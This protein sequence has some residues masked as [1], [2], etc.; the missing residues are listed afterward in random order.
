[1]NKIYVYNS[2]VFLVALSL[3]GLGKAVFSAKSL[4]WR[5]INNFITFWEKQHLNR[6]FWEDFK[7]LKFW[8]LK[9]KILGMI[10]LIVIVQILDF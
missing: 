3:F 10:A 7:Q 6:E 2:F 5:D 9:T 1:M 4:Y 8:M